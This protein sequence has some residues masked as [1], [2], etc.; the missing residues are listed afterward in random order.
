MKMKSSTMH[1]KSISKGTSGILISYSKYS[2]RIQM[3]TNCNIYRAHDLKSMVKSANVIKQQNNLFYLLSK[4]VLKTNLVRFFGH[5]FTFLVELTGLP[6]SLS[7]A[8][9]CHVA[10]LTTKETLVFLS[11]S[12]YNLAIK[13]GKRSIR[14]QVEEQKQ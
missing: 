10:H 12:E 3:W 1:S 6:F 14:P 7:L 9:C 13:L 2:L 8:F 11:W 5:N 4:R